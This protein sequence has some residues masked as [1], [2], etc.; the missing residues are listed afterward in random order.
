MQLALAGLEEAAPLAGRINPN[1]A[2]DCAVGARCLRTALEG[3][4]LN[5]RINARSIKDA[6]FA[7]GRLREGEAMRARAEALA[8]QVARD[9]ETKL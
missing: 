3:A 4:F 5:V 6:D 7:A 9:V 2:S 8:A 1:L